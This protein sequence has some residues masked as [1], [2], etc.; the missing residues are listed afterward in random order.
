MVNASLIIGYFVIAPSKYVIFI[1]SY[2][3]VM[4]NQEIKKKTNR[5]ESIFRTHENNKR[6]EK[7]LRSSLY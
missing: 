2:I 4:T 5:N 6:F 3:N 1:L 7:P